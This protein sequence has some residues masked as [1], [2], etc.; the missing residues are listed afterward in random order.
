[1][2]EDP[3]SPADRAGT[4]VNRGVIAMN[5]RDTASA[6]AD[7]EAALALRPAQAEALMNR[8]SARIAQGRFQEGLTDTSRALQLGVRYPERAYF[9]RALAREELNDAAGA[10]RDFRQAAQL[11]PE[12]ELPR[13]ELARF[14][15]RPR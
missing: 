1:L 5:R 10:Y 11:K 13:L 14:S 3:L 12:W 7:F 8:G 9:N 4:L 15:V 2:S 6:L